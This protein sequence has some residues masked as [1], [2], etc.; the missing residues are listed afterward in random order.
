[1]SIHTTFVGRVVA[2]PKQ[3]GNLVI[4]RAVHNPSKSSNYESRFV[5][6]K[7]K[8][9]SNDGKNALKYKQKDDII[10]V[11]NIEIEKWR[12]GKGFSDVMPFPRLETPYEIRM[13]AGAE[14]VPVDDPAAADGDGSD[15]DP[16]ADIPA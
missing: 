4:I 9:D 13:R 8:A 16:F 2:E 5:E 10:A 14:D 6:L 12:N 7:F 1:M 3:F 11:G 15:A